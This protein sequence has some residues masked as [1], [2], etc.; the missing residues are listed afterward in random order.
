MEAR[1]RLACKK[2]SS[3]SELCDLS[4]GYEFNFTV[5]EKIGLKKSITLRGF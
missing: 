4:F 3:E 5:V 2:R 1:D